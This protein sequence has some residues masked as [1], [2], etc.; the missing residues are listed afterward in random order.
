MVEIV[1]ITT[2]QLTALIRQAVSEVSGNTVPDEILTVAQAARFL[3]I[4]PDVLRDL[5]ERGEIPCRDVGR[6]GIR[7]WRYSRKA[8]EGW[9]QK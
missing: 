8:L 3:S 2:D 4:S 7:H 9:M 5:S 6:S 1:T